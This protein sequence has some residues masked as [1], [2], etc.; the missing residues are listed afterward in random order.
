MSTPETRPAAL[1]AG[2]APPGWRSRRGQPGWRRAQTPNRR[3]RSR[4]AG[5][6]RGVPCA[7]M[8]RNRS[9]GAHDDRES[10]NRRWPVKKGP[11]HSERLT[12]RSKHQS[13]EDGRPHRSTGRGPRRPETVCRQRLS[14]EGTPLVRIDAD[15][16]RDG[17]N[18]RVG[19]SRACRA[20]ARRSHRSLPVCQLRGALQGVRVLFVAHP[21]V[22]P[23]GGPGVARNQ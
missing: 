10:P 9:S 22:I 18:R 1:P 16:W 20:A 6:E 15:R 14:R 3:R 19:C 4:P 2:V 12:G 23:T 21:Q 7:A 8:I 17:R 13:T 5:V 11:G